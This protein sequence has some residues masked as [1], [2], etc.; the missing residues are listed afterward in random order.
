MGTSILSDYEVTKSW[1]FRIQHVACM[2]VGIL[3]LYFLPLIAV[4][5]CGVSSESICL[6]QE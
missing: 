4:Q 5:I 2:C 1:Q 6:E 3:K